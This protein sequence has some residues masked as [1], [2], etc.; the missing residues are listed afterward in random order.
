MFI[1]FMIFSSFELGKNIRRFLEISP[2]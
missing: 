1:D 2:W